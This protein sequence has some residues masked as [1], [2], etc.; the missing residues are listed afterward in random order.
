MRG[1][2]EELQKRV[3]EEKQAAARGGTAGCGCC[4]G[5]IAKLREAE[6][7]ASFLR[8]GVEGAGAGA[9][10]PVRSLSEISA[11]YGRPER[12]VCACIS[13]CLSV[14]MYTYVRGCSECILV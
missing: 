14:G 13:R 3:V 8:L 1:F 12:P 9:L 5:M 2:A 11:I 10:V 4:A 7:E 6:Q